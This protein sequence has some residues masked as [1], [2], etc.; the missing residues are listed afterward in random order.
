MSEKTI[1]HLRDRLFDALD[2]LADKKN[3]MD[4]ARAEAIAKVAQA[5]IHSCKVENDY[6]KLSGEQGS[7]FMT[8]QA[9]LP[10]PGGHEKGDHGD[11]A[12][13]VTPLA[14]GARVI[15]HRVR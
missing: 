15:R 8:E 9:R 10:P 7:G 11:G 14:N 12:T 2:G 4:I 5:L 13:T 1:T 3:P 6:M